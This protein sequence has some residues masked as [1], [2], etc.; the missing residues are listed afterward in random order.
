MR[1]DG[2]IVLIDFA[3][4]LR[5]RSGGFLHRLLFRRL[6]RVDEAAYLK[7]KKI[8]APQSLTPE[9]E[10]FLRRFALFRRLWVFNL[11][12]ALRHS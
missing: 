6:A 2:R 7:W 10:R 4:A 1:A 9:E 3:G 12:G 8:L 5:F 11:K